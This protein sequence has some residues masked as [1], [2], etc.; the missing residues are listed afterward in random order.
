MEYL[1][2]LQ[3]AKSQGF[4][5][6]AEMTKYVDEY[7][8]DNTDEAQKQRNL[9]ERRIKL[10]INPKERLAEI[11]E[12]IKDNHKIEKK[13][14]RL[15][16]I[17]K[18]HTEELPKLKMSL[19]KAMKI[20][21][22]ANKNEFFKFWENKIIKKVSKCHKISL[23]INTST[24]EKNNQFGV[25]V[26]YENI[27]VEKR[28]KYNQHIR[29]NTL[30]PINVTMPKDLT[31][32]EKYAFLIYSYHSR[33][34]TNED[35][36]TIT[37]IGATI[38]YLT[39]IKRAQ[40]RMK[41]TIWTLPLLNA[42]NN[43]KKIDEKS[44][45]CVIDFIWAI[46]NNKAGFRYYTK[47][48][49]INEI[50][51]VCNI[52]NGISTE[53][54]IKWRDTYHKNISVFVVNPIYERFFASASPSKNAVIKLCYM[55]KD[56]HC[57]PIL[58]D[59]ICDIISKKGNIR[60]CVDVMKWTDTS[61][62]I[63][64]C[65]NNTDVIQAIDND[66]LNGHLILLPEN[67]KARDVMNDITFNKLTF[68]EYIHY[69]SR[70]QID[71]FL[72]PDMQ[73]M[74]VSNNDYKLRKSICE[75]MYNK[76]PIDQFQWRNQTLTKLATLLFETMIGEVPKSEY[77]EQTVNMIDLFPT[78]ALKDFFI[79]DEKPMSDTEYNNFQSFD[80]AKAYP[81]I[82]INNDYDF[83]IYTIHDKIEEFK[84]D[85]EVV[86]GEYFIEK[87]ITLPFK[88]YNNEPVIIPQGVF[89]K[90]AILYFLEKGLIK[91]S[92]IKY[93]I[94][95]KQT[96]KAD[97][98]K[99][100]IE[101][102]FLNFEE[103]EAKQLANMFIGFLGTKY[104]KTNYGYLTTCIEDCLASWC[105]SENENITCSIMK[106]PNDTY[107]V[108]YG[109]V[110]RLFSEHQS[111]NRHIVCDCNILL[112]DMM[113]K[114]CDEKSI[115][116]GY[117]TDCINVINPV[118]NNYDDKVKNAGLFDLLKIGKIFNDRSNSILEI[119][120]HYNIK[121][122]NIPK[123]N[124]GNGKFVSAMAGCGKTTLLINDA[125]KAEN[126]LILSFT[127][128]AV[129]VLKDR[130]KNAPLD[131]S[132][133]T[134]TFDSYFFTTDE[135]NKRGIEKLKN[136]TVF[137]DE[138][139]MAPNRFITLIYHAF[140][141]YGIT[142]N[143][144]GDSNQCPPVDEFKYDY[145]KS[146]AVEQMC[147]NKVELQYIKECARYDNKMYDILCGFLRNGK[148]NTYFNKPK[149]CYKNICYKNETRIRINKECAN[150]FTKDKKYIN[151]TFRKVGK[152][153]EN[154]E[155]KVC[156]GMPLILTENLKEY[157]FYNSEIK[158]LKD[159]NNEFATIEEQKIPIHIFKKSF[160]LGYCVTVYR[161]QG[162]SIN[163]PYN[164][165]DTKY[166]DKK[167]LY[168]A[169]SRTT[170]YDYVNM[171]EGN[172]RYYVRENHNIIE[173]KAKH[174]EYKN[175]KIYQI[176]FEDDSNLIYV[177]STIQTLE[178]RLKEHLDITKNSV[179]L[180]YAHLKPYITKICDCPTGNKRKLEE[181]EKTYINQ[182][183]KDKTSLNTKMNDTN[184]KKKTY[185]FKCNI[186][187][188]AE[189]RERIGE[190]IK[191]FNDVKECRLI[192][193]ATING[194]K[195]RKSKCYKKCGLE[196]ATTEMNEIKDMWINDAL[197]LKFD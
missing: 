105:E 51:S 10:L 120:R 5:N 165:Y 176:K 3:I 53:D 162:D 37:A 2:F 178:E 49:L 196:K 54:I 108:K 156:K 31:E 193:Q 184:K 94:T 163:E 104:N 133:N 89:T 173:R 69:D 144:Y 119:E 48:K 127:N 16:N 126:P 154:E 45:S 182:Y 141:T 139:S 189:I 82:L 121:E 115:I 122:M 152:T 50:K 75:K 180:N 36:D 35:Y 52:K 6:D 146:C 190:K 110:E 78:V 169:L 14:D 40:Q 80:I 128:K 12:K 114:L 46:V 149:F 63:Y 77:N 44:G 172:L 183:A 83:P 15:V 38:I 136:K 168:T 113:Y 60:Q 55:V 186:T 65:K 28:E 175:A 188:E 90:K 102:I 97:T 24:I 95:S 157:K 11:K 155:Y 61:D 153:T 96:L 135:D 66:E 130:F 140:L 145:S 84:C 56:N 1:K 118:K 20:T 117:N 109:K 79:N 32:Q 160:S 148:L 76:F 21:K 134:H 85:Y 62:K 92:D 177:G 106:Q 25:N 123:I 111:L 47:D 33:N 68:S 17:E 64:E 147:G 112:I 194:E 41:S 74:I 131:L 166:M 58:N 71:G 7:P 9:L 100:F 19:K 39:P 88:T 142:V 167:Q 98:F 195:R 23:T 116:V 124:N 171:E 179:I 86:N 59:T 138:F 159:I 93:Y 107:I 174:T 57:Y 30:P 181:I 42:L 34:F 99:N 129:Q 137:I 26:F 164:I 170:K 125:Q 27:P 70:N 151:I 197:V 4:I 191:I 192:L 87:N 18:K 81:S 150:E 103:K 91:K 73:K 187:T 158:I 143:M 13:I 101:Y 22:T 185:E 161:Y 67:V 132:D 72:S 43:N 8:T 29:E